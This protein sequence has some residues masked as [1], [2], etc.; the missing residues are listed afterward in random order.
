M[1]SL[2]RVTKD[3]A[4][5]GKSHALALN[6][7]AAGGLAGVMKSNLGPKGTIKMYVRFMVL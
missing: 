6:I 3:A 1:S 7:R 4:H 5:V 2:S